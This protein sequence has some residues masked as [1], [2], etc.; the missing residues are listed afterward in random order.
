MTASTATLG[1]VYLA[2]YGLPSFWDENDIY[3]FGI[4]AILIISTTIACLYFLRRKFE[5]LHIRIHTAIAILCLCFLS[6]VS[7]GLTIY[8]LAEAVLPSSPNIL[9]CISGFSLSFLIGFITPGAPGG[10]GVREASFV[11]LFAST[12]GTAE[13]LQIILA[14]R[15][16]SILGDI[17]LFLSA[18]AIK[19]LQPR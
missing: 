5:L 19:Q 6:A 4:C 11:A 12:L 17:L 3:P 7:G 1:F 8:I 14:F 18:Y 2:I 15:F 16:L 13:S 10:A 9:L